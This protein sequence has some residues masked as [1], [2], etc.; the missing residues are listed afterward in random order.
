MQRLS[1]HLVDFYVHPRTHQPNQDTER[2]Q[3]PGHCPPMH[4]RS[5][6]QITTVLTVIT[7]D[8]FVL[9]LH[10]NNSVYSCSAL[11][12][13]VI[14]VVIHL[15]IPLCS[16]LSCDL[17]HSLWIHST[18]GGNLGCVQFVVVM[19]KVP[20]NIL[21]SFTGC[22]RPCFPLFSLVYALLHTSLIMIHTA[23][24]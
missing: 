22:A 3:H 10:V 2:F 19:N 9:K 5:L 24:S 15:L 8:M 1:A 14:H 4:T 6:P 13:W 17:D 16:V 20:T 11:Y 12:L 23:T 18:V 7:R 21:V